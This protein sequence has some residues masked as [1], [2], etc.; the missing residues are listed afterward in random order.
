MGFY[1]GKE[2]FCY[3]CRKKTIFT[4]R[5]MQ[6][7][8]GVTVIVVNVLGFGLDGKIELLR[9]KWK[10]GLNIINILSND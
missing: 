3:S 6:R 5:D 2:I 7:K 9:G 10:S 8:N 1:K 4:Y